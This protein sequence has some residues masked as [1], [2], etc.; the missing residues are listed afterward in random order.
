M[1]LITDTWRQLVRRKLWPVALLLV[2]AMAAVPYLLAS[3]PA[4]PAAPVVPANAAVAAS[5]PVEGTPV[6][7][8]ADDSKA[9]AKRKRVLG[10]S[11]DPFEPAP[12]PK[13]K[14]SAA[15]QAEPTATATATATPASPPAAGGGSTGGGAIAGPV[16]TPVPTQTFKAGT[17]QVRFGTTEKG[18]EMKK[19][20]LERLKTLPSASSPVL[21]FMGLEDNDKVAKFMI[22][23]ESVTAEGDGKCDPQPDSCET[24]TLRK[25]DT[26]FVTVKGTG[27][28]DAEY[29]LDLEAIYAKTTTVPVAVAASK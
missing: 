24:L 13:A 6:V 12:L 5:T 28:A 15:K 23:G 2:G 22:T 19:L 29:E 10:A 21:V 25:G 4:A 1:N 11:K 9:P 17:V 27:N 7:A 8:L 16:A 3:S 14:K 26:E 18:A 20:T